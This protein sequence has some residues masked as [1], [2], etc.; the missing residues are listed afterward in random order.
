MVA[1]PA[2]SPPLHTYSPPLA[3]FPAPRLLIESR[4]VYVAPPV[5][6]A[7]PPQVWYFCRD[8]NLY[9]PQ[10]GHCPS[11]WVRVLADGTTYY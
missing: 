8:Y 5:Y 2:Y 6:A 1:R 10:V 9:H 11:P 7:P 4:P 3:V